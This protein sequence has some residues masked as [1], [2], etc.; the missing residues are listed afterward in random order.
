MIL[1]LRRRII[2]RRKLWDPDVKMAWYCGTTP[3]RTISHYIAPRQISPAKRHPSGQL[4]A[5]LANH[6]I[7]QNIIALDLQRNNALRLLNHIFQLLDAVSFD[8]IRPNNDIP[9]T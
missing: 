3:Y 9:F 1:R 6:D 8:T 7:K 5:N 2:A 4:S